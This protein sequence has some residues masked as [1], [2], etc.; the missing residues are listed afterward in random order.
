VTLIDLM[1]DTASMAHDTTH[2][3]RHARVMASR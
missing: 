2:R 1:I 3:A